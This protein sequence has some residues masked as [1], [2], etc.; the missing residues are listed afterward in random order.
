MYV[1][2]VRVQLI[3]TVWLKPNES[4]V[5]EVS[6]A[7]WEGSASRHTRSTWDVVGDRSAAGEREPSSHHLLMAMLKSCS[8]TAIRSLNRY[9]RG[10]ISGL[11]SVIEPG[12][13]GGEQA[14][15][16]VVTV[17]M[18]G[19][20][21]HGP[22]LFVSSFRTSQQRRGPD[23]SL[24][25]RSAIVSS[26]WRRGREVRRIGQRCTLT[27]EMRHPRNSP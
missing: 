12:E 27:L 18:E 21:H 8:P 9:T 22:M 7:G 6:K 26:V 4:V 3:Q 15:V 20:Q 14:Q 13:P 2:S 10:L 16:N 23:S 17:D 24:C 19:D 1:P 11:L 5:T 25:W